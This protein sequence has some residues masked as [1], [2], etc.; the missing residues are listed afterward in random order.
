MV[1]INTVC[2]QLILKGAAMVVKHPVGIHVPVYR[3][4]GDVKVLLV[5]LLDF[6]VGQHHVGINL[7]FITAG[8]AVVQQTQ[9]QLLA[10]LLFHVGVEKQFVIGAVAVCVIKLT[11]NLLAVLCQIGR[12]DVHACFAQIYRHTGM[13]AVG[14]VRIGYF[15]CVV[16]LTFQHCA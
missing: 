12:T 7:C 5:A 6:L 10:A 16:G 9:L 15:Y 3:Q 1:K 13:L 4:V 11:G 8:L 14:A 2:H